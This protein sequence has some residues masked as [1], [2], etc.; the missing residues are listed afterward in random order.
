MKINTNGIIGNLRNR[1]EV[2]IAL[3]AG[4]PIATRIIGYYSQTGCDFCFIFL[5]IFIVLKDKRRNYYQ[6]VIISAC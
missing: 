3:I 1:L 6:C 2:I 5:S 4:F